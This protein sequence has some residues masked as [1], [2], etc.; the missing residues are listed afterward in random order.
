[1]DRKGHYNDSPTAY[2]TAVERMSQPISSFWDWIQS[3]QSG[4]K[5]TTLLIVVADHG[6]HRWGA[7][8]EERGEDLRF[9]WDYSEHGDQCAGCREIPM[10]LAGPGIQTGAVVTS[11]HSLE[12]V[13]AT[14]AYALGVDLPYATGRVIRE[15]FV[16]TPDAS[17]SDSGTADVAID[18]GLTA[19]AAFTGDDSIR[20][21]VAI[22]GVELAGPESGGI[23]R[24]GVT[25]KHTGAGDVV[26]WREL[27]LGWGTDKVD[28]PW[29]PQC[30]IGSG[31]S[32][33]DMAFPME[34][35]YPFWKPTILEA[36]DGTLLFAFTD[37]ENSNAYG[38]TRGGV[39]MLSWTQAGG[40]VGSSDERQ[41]ALFPGNPSATDL[42]GTTWVAWA[43]SDYTTVDGKDTTNPARYTRHIQL[44]TVEGGAALTW[45]PVW[46][47][48]TDGCPAD[49][50]CPDTA[51]TADANGD[52]WN[53]MD[54]PALTRK[55][56]SLQ[57][58]FVAW[59]DAAV[60]VEVV[61]SSAGGAAFSK[62]QRAD[63]NGRA[64][65]HIQPVWA[66]NMLYFGQLSDADTVEVCRWDGSSTVCTDTGA[67]AVRSLA[68]DG[69]T[70]LA[71]ARDDAGAWSA[72]PVTFE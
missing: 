9:D 22:D 35:V 32:W 36:D 1:M 62:A 27:E 5:D 40:W 49:S 14:A 6:R 60:A 47:N 48:F 18:G 52:T 64:L 25:V 51:P 71:V 12:D 10:F 4:L 72:I 31:S 42:D 45:T 43:E 34:L 53:R 66:D 23:L 59:N 28:W 37:N 24:E 11:P 58:A 50:D 67:T 41:G 29:T 69:D 38:T 70:V 57:L 65:G 61:T 15:A 13:A 46:R 21:T 56:D 30:R 2:P 16:D 19:E 54:F 33:E 20:N 17:V 68:A 3:P 39:A 55:D 8:A 26:C 63:T 7:E 44:D